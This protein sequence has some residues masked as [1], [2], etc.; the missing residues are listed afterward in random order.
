M[1]KYTP[2]FLIADANC[3]V[4]IKQRRNYNGDISLNKPYRAGVPLLR[5][6]R[7]SSRGAG[8][9]RILKTESAPRAG[10]LFRSILWTRAGVRHR[11]IS[12]HRHASRL[13]AARRVFGGGD[14][15]R[16][17]DPV[18]RGRRKKNIGS[19]FHR[20]GRAALYLLARSRYPDDLSSRSFFQRCAAR[21][22]ARDAR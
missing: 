11:D 4:N 7:I 5:D 15:T 19:K 9:D 17:F 8:I 6:W 20:D 14:A 2:D 10:E 3:A 22:R 18:F 13:A 21:A 12:A 16:K 1:R